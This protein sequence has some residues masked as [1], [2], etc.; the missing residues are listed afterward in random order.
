[1]A[2]DDVVMKMDA[3]TAS[4]VREVEKAKQKLLQLGDDGEKAGAKVDKLS[5]MMLKLQNSFSDFSKGGVKNIGADLVDMFDLPKSPAE[6]LYRAGT[7]VVEMLK[8]IQQEAKQA[9]EDLKKLDAPAKSL[10]QTS[11]TLG[12]FKQSRQQARDM[13]V[14]YGMDPKEAM[15]LI[16]SA[17][18]RGAEKDVETFAAAKQF[19]PDLVDSVSDI[20]ESFG[21]GDSRARINKLLYAASSSKLNLDNFAPEAVKAAP[22]VSQAGG[23]ENELLAMMASG[24]G[25]FGKGEKAADRINRGA[26]EL[27]KG[28]FGGKGSILE[29]F[30]A[31]E[32]ASAENVKD[33]EEL[34]VINKR[35][36]EIDR[37][38]LEIAESASKRR[39]G[40]TRAEEQENTAL[41]L[42]DR[43]LSMRADQLSSK[44][45]KEPESNEFREFVQFMRTKRK[46]IEALEKGIR[47]AGGAAPGSDLFSE[48]KAMVRA[49]NE[50]GAKLRGRQAEAQREVAYTERG[51]RNIER[52]AVTDEYMA[53]AEERGDWAIDKYAKEVAAGL[54]DLTDR[55]AEDVKRDLNLAPDVTTVA[56]GPLA[57]LIDLTKKLVSGNDEQNQTLRTR[58]GTALENNSEGQK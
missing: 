33:M 52:K 28:G 11:A 43:R 24:A 41:K 14:K 48:K 2:K 4:F 10:I 55:D 54:A 12:E 35:K 57:V 9:A 42:E 15:D 50:E 49:D 56:K 25:F 6:L 26:G 27:I 31:Y 58:K 45:F 19:G 8:D 34:S 38:Q 22:L 3:Q 37:R 44:G 30:D 32:K 17:K 18:N 13:A 7:S 40:M 1:M 20:R 23:T 36:T 47:N 51:R 16:V 29:S 39:S 46:D 5:S 21:E 53:Q